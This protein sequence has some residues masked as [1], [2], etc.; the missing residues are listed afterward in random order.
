MMFSRN[1]GFD[2]LDVNHTFS[3]AMTIK[4]VSWGTKASLIENH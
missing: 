4:N 1:P 2:P 3:P